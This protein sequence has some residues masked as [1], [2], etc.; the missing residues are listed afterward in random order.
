MYDIRQFRPALYVLLVMGMTGFALASES[1]GLWLLS[2]GAILLNAW[3]VKTGHFRPL[4]RLVANLVTILALLYVT[5]QIRQIGAPHIL[6]IGQFLV[7]LQ[8]V[9]LYEQRANRDYAQLLVLSLLLMVAA[10]INTASLMFG[11]LLV[12]YLFLSLY[13]CLLFHLKVEAEHAKHALGID[14]DKL[15]PTTL[16]QDQRL[17]PQSMRR[18]TGLIAF[19]SVTMAVLVFVFFPRGAGAGMLGMQFRPAQTLTG[20]S[21]QVGFQSV[22]RITQNHAV[23]ATVEVKRN[24]QNVQG[25]Q[26]L[27]LRGLTLGIYTGNNPAMGQPWQWLR[28]TSDVPPI[29]IGP[30]G[31]S[32][33]F[34]VEAD[35]QGEIF[36]Q[37]ITLDPTGTSALFA[38][39]GAYRIELS[40]PLSVRYHPRDASLQLTEALLHR[41]NY[42]VYSDGRLR[43]VE[44]QG[45]LVGEIEQAFP[46]M[47]DWRW[48]R[49]RRISAEFP[50]S[51][52]D[53]RI[54]EYARRPEVSGRDA[55]GP[56]VD[57]R[58]VGEYV[59]PLD[60]DIARNIE[61]HLQQA[62]AYT[63]DLT[64][65]HRIIDQDPLV[66]F[67]YDFRRGHCE[68][69]AGA[70][71]LLCQS[72]GM[73]ARMVVG[74]KCDEF[75]RYG[76]YYVVRQSH[77]HAWVEV[78]G[79]DGYWHSFDPTSAQDARSTMEQATLWQK[80]KYLLNYLEH[81]W[82]SNVVAYDYHARRNLIEQVDVN[83]AVTMVNTGQIL[84]RVRGWLNEA[85]FYLFS[86]GLI[87]LAMTVMIL[88]LFLAVGWYLYEQ[89]RL[90]QRA[91][92]IGL[93]ELPAG[94]QMRLA[95]QLGFYDELM[96]MLERRNI[97]RPA[98]LTPLEFSRSLDHLPAEVYDAVRRLTDLF[99][100][101]RF[102][103]ARLTHAQL[104]HLDN[105][106]QRIARSLG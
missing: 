55:Q 17:L 98:H 18:L 87:A 93:D 102:G 22:A 79:D 19:T 35:P 9:K 27:L 14:Q 80:V 85:N 10:S 36:Q 69:F 99:Y 15:N 48:R 13:C 24:G 61:Q 104:R 86:S 75:N 43:H 83:L 7:L 6:L 37:N 4:P 40:R 70:M 96:Q 57:R 88:V 73:Q 77:A 58:P 90:R 33:T 74:F 34:V 54:A 12:A 38:L 63:L 84:R 100:R 47:R 50:A 44:P 45:M 51:V 8:L 23:V 64:D 68:Y 32:R 56:L 82:A 106:I 29:E 46:G 26:P 21:E 30:E 89:W 78:L 49:H 11:I 31:T 39:P 65:T 66:A 105:V 20:F 72:L 67:L 2:V 92:R 42:T 97:H 71:T 25:T 81:V 101:V 16:R 3:L 62:F 41:L 95:R 52:I 1:P 53:P 5:L 94:D 28:S 91:H 103:N 59:T 76:G 60:L